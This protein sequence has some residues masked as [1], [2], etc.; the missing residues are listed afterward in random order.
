MRSRVG[1][2]GATVF[3]GVFGPSLADELRPGDTW[4]LRAGPTSTSARVEVNGAV[5]ELSAAVEHGE[6]PSVTTTLALLPGQ[7]FR[8]SLDAGEPLLT[9][10]VEFYRDQ[11]RVYVTTSDAVRE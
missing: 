9:R 3:F 10:W 5:Y 1:V 4:S 6:A 2:V 7:R 11:N 8:M